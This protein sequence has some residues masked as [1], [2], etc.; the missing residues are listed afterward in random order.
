MENDFD[1]EKLEDKEEE[2]CYLVANLLFTIM[3]RGIDVNSKDAW[4]VNNV[5]Y[6]FYWQLCIVDESK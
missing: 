1:P 2:L 6:H 4:K 5:L 3:W